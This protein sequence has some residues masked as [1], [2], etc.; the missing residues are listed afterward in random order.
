MAV[1]RH[2]WLAT[3]WGFTLLE[4]LNLTQAKVFSVLSIISDV[5]KLARLTLS[6]VTLKLDKLLMKATLKL[7]TWFVLCCVAIQYL[8]YKDG[9]LLISAWTHGN[10]DMLD[11]WM[12]F[13][14]NLKIQINLVK[15]TLQSAEFDNEKLLK[16]CKKC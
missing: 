4:H 6:I 7:C 8:H 15:P 9:K 3:L 5:Y 16:V 10:P 14:L 12:V 1:D 11:Q 13:Q 2:F